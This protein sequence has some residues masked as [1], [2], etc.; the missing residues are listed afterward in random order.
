M[1][2]K[3]VCE[4][5][6]LTK[7]AIHYYIDCGLIH[8][9]KLDNNYFDFNDENIKILNQIAFLRKMDVSID[10]IKKIYHSPSA[11]NFFLVEERNKLFLEVEDKLTSLMDLTSLILNLP[12]NAT[13]DDIPA[14][15]STSREI[16]NS[17]L[18]Q[19]P[20]DLNYRMLAIYIFA[21]Y[22]DEFATE[23]KKYLWK[24]IELEVQKQFQHTSLEALS[25]YSIDNNGEKMLAKYISD[26]DKIMHLFE[27]EDIAPMVNTF[28]NR[29]QKFLNSEKAVNAWNKHYE[30]VY[31]PTLHTYQSCAKEVLKEFSNRFTI[32]NNKIE[33]IV[34][35]VDKIIS[36]SSMKKDLYTKCHLTDDN[37]G[38]SLFLLFLFNPID[39]VN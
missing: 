36:T 19:I 31:V 8:V 29:L 12:H 32:C 6:G 4:K 25:Y 20:R 2:M 23:Y 38:T 24:K 5:T 39:Y 17:L 34:I 33:Q 35:A 3:E 13:P 18:L 21:P 22:T 11:L 10:T 9:L 27:I 30:T 16:V 26:F 7:K 28:V 37:Y 14:E 15:I 1:K